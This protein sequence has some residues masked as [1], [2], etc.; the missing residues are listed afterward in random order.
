[1]APGSGERP[2]L[3]NISDTARW[4]A[5]YRARESARPDAVFRDPYAAR[6]AGLKGE[7]IADS[8][9]GTKAAYWAV[10][11][12]TYA[13]DRMVAAESAGGADM[14]INMAAGLDTRPYRMKLPASLVWVEVDLPDL[15]SYKVQKL[16]G[17][18]PS[19]RLERVACDISDRAS[20]RE[21]LGKLNLRARRI[22]VITEGLLIYLSE[23]EVSAVAEDL[24][25][26]SHVRR[27]ALEL[28]N[29]VLLRQ[30]QRSLGQRL[31]E[32]ANAPL[33]FGPA[34][35]PAYFDRF[36]WRILEA[37]S[38]LKTAAQLRRLP[39]YLKPFTLFADRKPSGQMPAS[40]ICLLEKK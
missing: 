28:V 19:C 12:R 26:A 16:A 27:W 4:V 34:E 15:L 24:N 20:R 32:Q 37:H 40:W 38:M 33:K 22:L 11:A 39:W 29:P 1:M 30:L 6:L 23:P 9:P 8:L 25:W 35:G 14:V 31:A 5:V 18:R 13:I 10:V 3:R 7:A 21:L 2:P 36:G 17:E